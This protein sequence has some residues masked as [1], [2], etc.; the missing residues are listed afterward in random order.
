MRMVTVDIKSQFEKAQN[1]VLKELYYYIIPQMVQFSIRMVNE[2]IP[3]QAEFRNLTGNTLTSYAFGVY[4][5]GNLEIM[6]FNKDAEP[7]LRNKLIKGET[8][9]NF[10]DY[11]GN[12]RNFFRANIDTDG[13]LGVN[14]SMA[15]LKSYQ[16]KSKYGIVFT[17]GTE[18]STY[19]E[20]VRE[21]NVLTDAYEYS[22]SAFVKSFKPMK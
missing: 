3:S 22:Q 6:G 5:M 18:Y 13:K 15:F 9:V 8:V 16:P 1:N 14:T 2:K 11:D 12:I 17:T 21:L 19:L 4:Y 20:N 10:E 7:A